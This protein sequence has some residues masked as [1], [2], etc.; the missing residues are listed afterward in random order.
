MQNLCQADRDPGI[1]NSAVLFWSAA[2]ASPGQLAD[3]C[4]S[5]RLYCAGATQTLH[6]RIVS[7]APGPLESSPEDS[8]GGSGGCLSAALSY[9]SDC[10][11]SRKGTE[12]LTLRPSL[13]DECISL[14]YRSPATSLSS[15]G[16]ATTSVR[17][18]PPT[19]MLPVPPVSR[20]GR[21]AFCNLQTTRRPNTTDVR[22]IHA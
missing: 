19:G 8:P 2:P 1:R 15:E 11:R 10:L 14:P 12:Y 16:G 13:S 4:R 18:Q 3:C 6:L 22:R 17:K 9:M 7:A 20:R 21:H 5:S